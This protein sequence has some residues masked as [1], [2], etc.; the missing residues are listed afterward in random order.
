V[1]PE[2]YKMTDFK[3][4]GKRLEDLDI[5]RIAHQIGVG[6]DEVHAVLDTETRGEGFDKEGR[7]IILFEPHR[8]Y[9]NLS[10]AER[11]K[12]VRA[13]LAYKTWGQRP[14]P[15]DSYPRLIAAM[16]IN[17]AAA[18]M[19]ASWGLPQIMGENF[20]LAGYQSVQQMVRDFMEDE[21][22]Q[23]QAMITFIKNAKLDDELRALAKLTRPTR[24]DD[25][26]PFV[27]GYNG[28]GY[29]KNDYHT[30]FARNHNKWRKIRNTPW[31]PATQ[32][33]SK[34]PDSVIA[35]TVPA[36]KP[37]GQV[38]NA[39]LKH[40]QTLLRDRGYPEV[41]EADGCFGSR[42]RNAI[43]SFQADNHFPLT[44]AVSDDLIAQIVKAS[45][46]VMFESRTA[47]TASDLAAHPVVSVSSWAKKIG[48]LVLTGSGLGGFVNGKVDI[49]AATTGV[50]KLNSLYDSVASLSPW[51]LGA[52]AGLAVIFIGSRVIK[53]YVEAYRQ[54]RAL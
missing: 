6:E 17:E 40:I 4:I 20:K 34:K 48:T 10:G 44:G 24:P 36:T 39:T 54:G 12:A 25:C 52:A 23:L 47:A 42:T 9:Q 41:G 28:K 16:R 29:E 35:V 21:E 53:H 8:F 30:K 49:D 5:P 37:V 13:G 15:K 27:A 43:L 14:Y 31:S 11:T 26:R 50:D 22:N 1:D 46:R 32:N 51:L 33:V 2:I 3:G 45:P 7:S 38:L 18:L 19:S